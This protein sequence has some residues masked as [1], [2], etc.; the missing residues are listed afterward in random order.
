MQMQLP[1]FPPKN[2][3]P[4]FTKSINEKRMLVKSIIQ[5][6]INL[7]PDYSENIL[8]VELFSL[9]TPRE[10]DAVEN[11]CKILNEQNSIYPNT[12]LRIIYKMST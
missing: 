8:T 5:S 10:N 1:L 2:I 11:I 4:Y 9:S 7:I 6:N 3:S 12:K